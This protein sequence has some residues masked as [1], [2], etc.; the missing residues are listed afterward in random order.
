MTPHPERNKNIFLCISAHNNMKGRRAAERQ[1]AVFNIQEAVPRS[2]GITRSPIKPICA[3]FIGVF[4]GV[5]CFPRK[6]R[7][8]LFAVDLIGAPPRCGLQAVSRR[9]LSH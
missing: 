7:T 5:L 8:D 9:P 2:G 4:E 6:R 3:H 1:P